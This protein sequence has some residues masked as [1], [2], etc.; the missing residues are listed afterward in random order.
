MAE[1]KINLDDRKYDALK[2]IFA[3]QGRDIDEEI[4]AK[5]EDMYE[6]L[7]PKAERDRI[8]HDTEP[9]YPQGSFA[10]FG[11]K[12]Q[13]ETIYFTSSDVMTLYASAKLYR[14]LEANDEC[15]LTLDSFAYRYF[16]EEHTEI[17]S[18][19]LFSVLTK[20][21]AN[22][23]RITA[24]I[25]YNF[26]SECVKVH[27]RD[28]VTVKH[29]TLDTLMDFLEA[30]ELALVRNES[31]RGKTLERFLEGKE[32]LTEL[33]T[34]K[35]YLIARLIVCEAASKV[36]NEDM[37][38]MDGGYVDP[39]SDSLHNERKGLLSAIGQGASRD[40]EIVSP[41]LK[42][43]IGEYT[44]RLWAKGFSE[45]YGWDKSSV[46]NAIVNAIQ[47]QE[48]REFAGTVTLDDTDEDIGITM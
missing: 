7:V 40:I 42:E 20:A 37:D 48:I 25:E 45:H 1:R 15:S 18:E 19:N 3:E 13:G 38:Y 2:R 6:D 33:T 24:A 30:A 4:A 39:L 32:Y 27:E 43:L 21:M 47:P 36:V 12:D 41:H 34:S 29:Y 17:I 44:D 9:I 11:F 5:I 35:D 23:E 31:E 46:T 8:E 14:E 16:G 28:G 22:D 26:D 10:I